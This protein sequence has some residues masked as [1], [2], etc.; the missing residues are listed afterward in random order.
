[1]QRTRDS[2][3]AVFSV[4]PR[5]EI[6]EHTG[7]QFLVFNTMF[8]LQAHCCA[9]ISSSA[10]KLLLMPDLINLWLSGMAV[11]EYTN[12]TT[13]QMVNARSRTWDTELV[14]KLGLPASLLAE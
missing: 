1:D 2:M 13:T 5:R 11:T 7:I 3:A 10:K 8:Q 12:A 9:G 14:E 4:V 6:F